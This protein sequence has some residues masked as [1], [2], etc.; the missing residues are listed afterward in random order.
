MNNMVEK[1]HQQN[2]FLSRIHKLLEEKFQNGSCKVCS[3]EQ[4]WEQSTRVVVERQTS[5]PVKLLANL[6]MTESTASGVAVNLM[7]S[8]ETGTFQYA[9]K[10]TKQI[11]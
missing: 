2:Q 11:R 6:L 5:I 10:N 1:S 9:N 3:L 4:L 8:Q 7:K